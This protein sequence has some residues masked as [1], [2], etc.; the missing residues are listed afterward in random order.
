M[1]TSARTISGLEPMLSIEE[2]AEYL[3]LPVRTL[4]DWRQS[5][6]GP[7]AIHVDRQLRYFVSDVQAWLEEQREPAPADASPGSSEGVDQRGRRMNVQRNPRDIVRAIVI[8]DYS[9]VVS[10]IEIVRE[11]QGGDEAAIAVS[12]EDEKGV[13]RR[14]VFGLRKQAD[15]MWRPSGGSL[16]SARLSSERDVW[17]MWGGW[18]GDSRERTRPRWLGCRPGRGVGPSHRR[19]DGP[20]AR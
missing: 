10:S 4:Y 1:K 3:A 20:D 2:L 17:M 6:R 7:R 14:G 11:K 18:G 9:P 5:G 8:A 16:G 19:H 13:A 15:G 12:F